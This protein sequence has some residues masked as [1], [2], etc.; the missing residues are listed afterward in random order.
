MDSA[1]NVRAVDD[2][3]CLTCPGGAASAAVRGNKGDEEDSDRNYSHI[4]STLPPLLRSSLVF[5]RDNIH[6]VR[7]HT[8]FSQLSARPRA[9]TMSARPIVR[10]HLMAK[11]SRR[12]STT[13]SMSPVFR[14]G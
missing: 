11:A 13:R 8:D 9:P 4:P 2:D 7:P 3:P 5:N 1:V 12:W 14:L 6:A 10:N